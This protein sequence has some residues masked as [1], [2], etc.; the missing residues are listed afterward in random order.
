MKYPASINQ[1]KFKDHILDGLENFD[2]VDP[3]NFGL[4]KE[5]LA[6]PR[7]DVFRKK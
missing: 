5:V 6:H 2:Q 1:S 3:A 4:F 7:F